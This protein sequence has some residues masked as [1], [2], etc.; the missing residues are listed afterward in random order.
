MSANLGAV[1]GDGE[2]G[3]RGSSFSRGTLRCV[4]R[5]LRLDRAQ[6]QKMQNARIKSIEEP[7]TRVETEGD[8]ALTMSGSGTVSFDTLYSALGCA[9]RSSLAGALGAVLDNQCVVAD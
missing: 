1:I 9:P 4:A 3:L 7:V 2:T 5:P 6:R 8:V